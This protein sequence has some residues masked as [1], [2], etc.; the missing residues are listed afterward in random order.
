MPKLLTIE[1]L[2]RELRI[3]RGT[4]YKISKQIKH[5]KIGRRILISEENL[6]EFLEKNAQIL[7]NPEQDNTKN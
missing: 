7:E 3:S 6:H 5:N 1:D 4:A 2:T